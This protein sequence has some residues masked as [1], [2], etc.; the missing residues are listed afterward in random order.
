M[1]SILVILVPIILFA[2]VLVGGFSSSIKEEEPIG[3][4]NPVR[5][6]ASTVGSAA[7]TLQIFNQGVGSST[8]T[9]TPSPS[10]SP[11]PSPGPSGTPTPT[12]PF[13]SPLPTP[14][15][16]PAPTPA[17]PTAHPTAQPIS[18]PFPTTNP[19]GPIYT[20]PSTGTP[21]CA[22]NQQPNA[23]GTNCCVSGGYADSCGQCCGDEICMPADDSIY[24][25]PRNNKFQAVWCE[26]KPV[27]YLYPPKPLLVDVSLEVT[28]DIITSIPQYPQGG[29]KGVYAEPTG[30]L[31][32]QAKKYS[33]LF[34]EVAFKPQKPPQGGFIVPRSGLR[35]GL[36]S[37][38]KR[39]GFNSQESA[40]LVDFWNNRINN[41]VFDPYILISFFEKQQKLTMDKVVITPQPDVFIEHILYFKGLDWPV[42][43]EPP[44]F[45]PIP[46]R[47]GFTAVEWGGIIDTN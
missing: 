17:Q 19:T 3:T 18:T 20:N 30:V 16:T 2:Y 44:Q 42:Q 35:F 37:L 22:Y 45:P 5:L 36:A 12:T 34:Y 41:N 1:K 26:V 32:Y 43:I 38:S 29:W 31:T 28:G 47:V 6:I 23:A 9:T 40:E 11:S 4:A 25:R 39:L 14:T 15:N 7:K 10:P 46:Q 8:V 21:V 33:E 13:Y 27:V 24:Y